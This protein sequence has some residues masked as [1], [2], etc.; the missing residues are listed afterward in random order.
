MTALRPPSN[1]MALAALPAA[2][3]DLET[4]GLD[5]RRD[6]IVQVAAI[7]MLGSRRDE[8]L[9]I[10]QL[11]DPGIPIPAP[12]T[13]IH[14]IDDQRVAGAPTFAQ[15]AANLREGFAGRVV[16]G[17]HIAFD[18]AILRHEADRAGVAWHE[19]PSLD[20]ALLLGALE[21]TLPDLSLEGVTRWLGVQIERRH[22]ALGDAEATAAVFAALLPRLR[23]ADVRTLGEALSLAVR[24]QDLILQQAHSEWHAV[25]GVASRAEA[26]P[27]PP[28]IDSYV[29]ERCLEEVMSAPPVVV[30][31]DLTLQ[32]AAELMTAR[33][34]GALLVGMTGAPPDG[35][36]TER[37]FL[38][39]TAQGALDSKV[40]TV[41]QVMSSPV[42]AL[43]TDDMLYRALG[44]MDHLGIRHLCVV[45]SAGAAVGM[46]SQRDLLQY[47]ARAAQEI[48]DTVSRAADVTAL[49]A[50]FSQVPAAAERLVAE[51]VGGI[52]VARVVSSELRAVTAR[53]A[54]LAVARLRAR[55]RD[56][57]AS[58][59]VLVLGSAGRGESLLAADQ[60]NA[61]IHSGAPG[62]D[63][64]FAE[65]GS[66]LST[67][68]DESGVP[69]CNGGVMASNAAWRGS[70]SEWRSR[71]GAWLGRARSEDLLNVDIFFDLVPVAGELQLARTLHAQAVEAASKA[72][73]F[74]AL[75]AT[76]AH[77]LLPLLGHFGR[78]RTDNG[79][80]DLKRCGLLPIVSVARAL[81]LR[82]G[83]ME[84]STP[85]RLRDATADGR[86][87]E[88]DAAHLIE[89]HAQTMTLVLRQQL[90]DLDAGVRPSSR[91]AVKS[92]RRGEV[93]HLARQLRR[94]EDIVQE[95]SAAMVR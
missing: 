5:V 10:D 2:V 71:V 9:Q 77:G 42:E 82:V 55:G 84:H 39:V 46:L 45:D 43:S 61:L 93:K 51:G 24:R 78:L 21:P 4:T 35:I 64:W 41:G 95:L 75:L 87:S 6:R 81:A 74:L 94:L 17:H 20:V 14:G 25:P 69:L 52:E 37:D 63:A 12:V 34:I 11:V 60:D 28:R 40:A 91:V 67:V 19:P 32:A 79:R 27:P 88:P 76:A 53:A 48:G 13:A 38:R 80:V 86:L 44:R 83:S 15:I 56:A 31:R 58:W 30:P 33:R 73:P 29:F 72:P 54:A 16:V 18:L 68:L 26:L 57:P 89:L 8:V 85:G 50:A 90:I 23:D 62:V 7:G 70:L 36:V 49:A 92:L 65:F 1:A 59:C 47:R 22:S 66:E 3:L